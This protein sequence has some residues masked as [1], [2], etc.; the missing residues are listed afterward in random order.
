MLTSSARIG[1]EAKLSQYDG[2]SSFK[3]LGVGDTGVG[4]MRMH[5][6]GSL[7]VGSG[8]TSPCDGFVV[9]EALLLLP[10][11]K[12]AAEAESKVVAITLGGGACFEAAEYYVC[13]SLTLSHS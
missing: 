4:H 12:V 5:A 9:S 3:D 1:S 8:S 6:T 7:P 11:A 10:T 2:V 13:D